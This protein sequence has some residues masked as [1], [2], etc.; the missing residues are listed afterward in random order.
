MTVAENVVTAAVTVVALVLMLVAAR[1]WWYTRSQK[2]LLLSLAFGLFF[3]KGLVLSV[4]LF[5]ASDW[6]QRLLLPSLVLDLVALGLFYG[7]VLRR[8]AS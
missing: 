7:A 4:G 6:A 5:L 1:S 2:V 8:S 3:V